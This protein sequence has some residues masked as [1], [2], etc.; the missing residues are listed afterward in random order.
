MADTHGISARRKEDIVD[1]LTRVLYELEYFD[2]RPLAF[3]GRGSLPCSR[4]VSGWIWDGA[5][6]VDVGGCGLKQSLGG[7]TPIAPC[8]ASSSRFI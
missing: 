8:N 7:T 1:W 6:M 5:T 3:A 4:N 2:H